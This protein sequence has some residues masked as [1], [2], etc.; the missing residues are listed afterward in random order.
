MIDLHSGPVD[1]G[2][3]HEYITIIKSIISD[4]QQRN[5]LNSQEIFFLF[6]KFFYY[7]C[8]F[9]CFS[10]LL[11]FCSLI[12]IVFFWGGGGEEGV[13][14]IDYP[15]P[16]MYR[17]PKQSTIRT[18]FFTEHFLGQNFICALLQLSTKNAL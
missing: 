17:L 7:Y 14:A 5:Q 18:T 4:L 3:N 11:K 1:G 13:C 10:I 12:Y 15:L 6:L 8:L 9:V 16:I 2:L